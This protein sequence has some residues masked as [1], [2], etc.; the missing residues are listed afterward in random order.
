ML[1]QIFVRIDSTILNNDMA[2]CVQG[3]GRHVSIA[4]V[5]ILSIVMAMGG[6]CLEFWRMNYT[7]EQ[8]Y[9]VETVE[10]VENTK[11][12]KIEDGPVIGL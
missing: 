4:T 1:L 7:R 2:T 10:D 5:G 9:T 3:G 12:E 8:V 6:S 11:N